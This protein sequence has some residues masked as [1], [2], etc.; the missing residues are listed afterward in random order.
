LLSSL[1]GARSEFKPGKEAIK[2]GID[3]HQDFCAVVLQLVDP[4][5]RFTK[6]AFLH[7]AAKS[8]ISRELAVRILI[9]SGA[10]FLVLL[11]ATD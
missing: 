8:P 3:A 5:Q 4:D 9:Q 11:D 7:L 6:E 1:E 2:L 10:I